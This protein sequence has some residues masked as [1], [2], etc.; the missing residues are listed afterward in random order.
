MPTPKI[1]YGFERQSKDIQELSKG[2]SPTINIRMAPWL[3]IV[4][5]N[6]RSEFDIAIK[7]GSIVAI[8]YFPTAL[9]SIAAGAYYVPAN[10]GTAGTMAYAAADVGLTLNKN[11]GAV[12]TTGEIGDTAALPANKPV[13]YNF[14]DF[15]H[16]QEQ[17]YNNMQ[18][19]TQEKGVVRQYFIE[20]PVKYAYQLGDP[21]DLV[22][23]DYTVQGAWR[24]LDPV[25]YA[26]AAKTAYDAMEQHIGRLWSVEPVTDIDNLSMEVP[27]PGLS[28]T[29]RDSDGI[30]PHL[31]NAVDQ[32]GTSW[33]AKLMINA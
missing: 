27:M 1:P 21:G 20:L 32:S 31:R 12:V 5:H 29:G 26:A 19:Q 17:M 24:V 28:L 30:P 13:G 16:D 8:E 22:V 11:T 6:R 18:I 4:E 33:R 10:G 14:F 2:V 23:A 15:Y 25:V 9:G 3:P 7:A